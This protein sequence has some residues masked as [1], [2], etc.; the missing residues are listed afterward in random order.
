MG[1]NL[2][3]SEFLLEHADTPQNL[4]DSKYRP[5]TMCDDNVIRHGPFI[6]CP[7]LPDTEKNMRNYAR[8]FPT[9][10][11]PNRLDPRPDHTNL[12]SDSYNNDNKCKPTAN[13]TNEVKCNKVI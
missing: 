2:N 5:V 8:I 7:Y 4:K 12:C 3:F 9:E 6:I 1:S 13:Y 10:S 11:K